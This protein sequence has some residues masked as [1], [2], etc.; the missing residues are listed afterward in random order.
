MTH[1]GNQIFRLYLEFCAINAVLGTR[2][3]TALYYYYIV[4]ASAFG[5]EGK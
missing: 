5:R 1:A 4:L 2:Y 3:H